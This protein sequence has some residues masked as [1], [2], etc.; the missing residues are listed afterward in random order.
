MYRLRSLST[1]PERYGHVTCSHPY[2]RDDQVCSVSVRSRYKRLVEGG[3]KRWYRTGKVTLPN[4]RTDTHEVRTV[5]QRESSIR[6][7]SKRICSRVRVRFF[8][9]T[10]RDRTP[11]VNK[12]QRS[13]SRVYKKGIY[14]TNSK[15]TLK[16]RPPTHHLTLWTQVRRQNGPS[17][18]RNINCELG[19]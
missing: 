6:P 3:W 11:T 14:K 1:I 10:F 7:T 8:K 16:P 13:Y 17:V 12:D 9:R 5:H 18:Y 15:V 2:V 19:Q 4:P